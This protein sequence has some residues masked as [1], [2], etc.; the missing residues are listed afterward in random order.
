MIPLKRRHRIALAGQVNNEVTGDAIAQATVK[1]IQAPDAFIQRL[2]LKTRLYGLPRSF[3][4]PGWSNPSF[5]QALTDPNLTLGEK[6]P[7]L[8]QLFDHL[9]QKHNNPSAHVIPDRTKTAPD[10]WF[11]FTDLPPG[12]YQL[13]ASLPRAKLR[14]STASLTVE[15]DDP[16]LNN[17]PA[18]N[19]P[20]SDKLNLKLWIK[21]TTLLGKIV[22]AE[23]QESIDLATVK[24]NQSE[25]P[26]LRFETISFKANGFK[27]NGSKV[28]GSKST[29]SRSIRPQTIENYD[30]G[31]WNYCL[32]DFEPQDPVTTVTVSAQG[33]I[34][35]TQNIPI[36]TGEIKKLNFQLH[37]Q[38]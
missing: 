7:I 15:L 20:F 32:S 6:F 9:D 13:E 4:R 26:T 10:G 24:I 22:D 33:Y 12:F 31:D 28:N 5:P 17:Q 25:D 36:Q 35:Q 11:Y 14:Y 3:T 34:S 8:Q 16:P 2:I 21:P 29:S 27:I 1:I 38:R 23:N 37:A 30:L 18:R 19:S